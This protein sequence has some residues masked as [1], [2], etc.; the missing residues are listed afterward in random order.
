MTHVPLIIGG[1][2]VKSK[3]I[4]QQVGLIDLLPTVLDIAC[5]PKD[6]R[7]MGTSQVETQSSERAYSITDP[8]MPEPQIAVR[9]EQY[10]WISGVD[11]Q[12]V[13]DLQEDPLE[14]KV[15]SSVPDVLKD[16]K[17]HYQQLIQPFQ[18]W[19]TGSP[20]KRHISDSECKRLMALGYTTCEQ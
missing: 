8:W 15:L 14:T 20:R 5:L 11:K 10:K 16:S 13:Y 7:F 12:L 18:Q 17:E 4:S 1:G 19:Q 9:T 6:K 2:G 3:R